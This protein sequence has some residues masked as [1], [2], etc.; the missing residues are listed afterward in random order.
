MRFLRGIFRE[1]FFSP[2]FAQLRSESALCC[3]RRLSAPS[4]LGAP[5]A[6]SPPRSWKSAS[7][8]SLADPGQ[9]LLASR[10]LHLSPFLIPC[11]IQTPHELTSTISSL[12]LAGTVVPRCL[13]PVESATPSCAR[14][15]GRSGQRHGAARRVQSLRLADGRLPGGQD[16]FGHADCDRHDEPAREC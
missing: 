5:P 9:R 14:T 6:A 2:S 3:P 8:S 4:T 16:R 12:A 11:S 15:G 13:Q 7:P 10:D 1:K